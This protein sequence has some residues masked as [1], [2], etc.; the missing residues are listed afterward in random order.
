MFVGKAYIYLY[1]LL[2]KPENSK[3]GMPGY[4]C[5]MLE[6]IL[7]SCPV[8]ATLTLSTYWYR[9]AD[10]L[11]WNYFNVFFIQWVHQTILQVQFNLFGGT[12]IKLGTKRHHDKLVQGK[13]TFHILY[14]LASTWF[15]G[16]SE[17]KRLNAR[18]FVWEFLQSG[19]LYRPGESLKRRS[20]SS[21]L[22]SKKIY[23]LGGA[24]FLW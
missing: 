21:S 4:A 10:L 8:A 19:M 15:R 5:I 2:Y 7:C 6:V 1:T 12:V 16:F 14:S 24:G 17:K 3:L 23:L 9:Y 20:K 18:G 11:L 13:Y 22:H